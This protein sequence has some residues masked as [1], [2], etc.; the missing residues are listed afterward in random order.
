[1]YRDLCGLGN[2]EAFNQVKEAKEPQGLQGSTD[3]V[4][5]LKSEVK[6]LT[7]LV[8]KSGIT[9][10]ASTT[11]TTVCHWCNEPGHIKP[12]CPNLDKPKAY[13]PKKSGGNTA[14]A[15]SANSNAKAG[16]FKVKVGPK[17]GEPTTTTHQGTT[18]KWCDTCKKWNSGG[19][20]HLTAEHVKGKGATTTTPASALAQTT[21]TTTP[22]LSCV[23]GYI[24]AIGEQV[25]DPYP[26]TDETKFIVDERD[27]ASI[28]SDDGVS[29]D[30]LEATY[31]PVCQQYF[32]DELHNASALH[33]KNAELLQQSCE[34]GNGVDASGFVT[35]TYKKPRKH[36][37]HHL[38]SS[39]GQR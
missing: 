31:C 25:T 16:E 17:P 13:V 39:T 36:D 37:T 22:S 24:G 4:K 30:A 2:W 11:K 32:C 3:T 15:S 28:L 9:D 19:K 29:A 20:A 23:A 21:S 33:A 35:V 8:K 6:R 5:S 34:G 27:H 12:N 10:T 7:K 14:K 18:Y 26:I 1:M 38:N